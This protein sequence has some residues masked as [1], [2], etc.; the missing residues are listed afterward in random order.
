MTDLQQRVDTNA[1][2]W[3]TAVKAD[4]E[5]GGENH[6][7]VIGVAAKALKTFGTP[8]LNS[9]LLESRLGS[10]P[11]LI[12]LLYRAGK[13]ISQDGVPPGRSTAGTKSD[14]DVFYAPKA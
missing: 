2:A 1:K 11:E 9:F 3:E 8:E 10:N 4:P 13:A 14:A 5:L 7:Q 12:R 6:Q